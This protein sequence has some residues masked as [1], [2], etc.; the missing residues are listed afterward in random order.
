MTYL[1]PSLYKEITA[2]ALGLSLV[3]PH[4]K[5]WEMV[6]CSTKLYRATVSSWEIAG[7]ESQ[8][9]KKEEFGSAKSEN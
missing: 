8:T 9:L 3:L 2:P 5:L 6:S 7:Y 4:L 1:I